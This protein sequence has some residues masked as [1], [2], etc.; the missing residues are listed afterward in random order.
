MYYK[1][2][3]T[4]IYFVVSNKVQI[5]IYSLKFIKSQISQY[6][7]LL[8]L[9]PEWLGRIERCFLIK[10]NKKYVQIVTKHTSKIFAEANKCKKLNRVV[11][12]SPLSSKNIQYQNLLIT[13]SSNQTILKW[14]YTWFDSQD[15]ICDNVMLWYFIHHVNSNNK[16]YEF[17][18]I[19]Y[20]IGIEWYI[21]TN[22]KNPFLYLNLYLINQTKQVLFLSNTLVAI[23]VIKQMSQFIR[24][25]LINFKHVKCSIYK[26]YYDYINLLDIEINIRQSSISIIK[27]SKQSIEYIFNILRHTL[28][29]KNE[30]GNWRINNYIK[31]NKPLFLVNHLLQLWSVYYSQIVDQLDIHKINHSIDNLFYSWQAKKQK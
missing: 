24:N 29:H 8:L 5:N 30:K 26:Y 3:L 9:K 11:I 21:Y 14:L 7:V 17:L 27:P 25:K 19:L 15:F 20:Y 12:R 6:I 2:L 28:Y 23:L 22:L 4:F 16:L 13:I 18:E 10:Q 31:T 1:K